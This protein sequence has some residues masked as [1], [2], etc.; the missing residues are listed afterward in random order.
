MDSE[1]IK[2]AIK[3]NKIK[4]RKYKGITEPYH[5]HDFKWYSCMSAAV[6]G[7][8]KF[9]RRLCYLGEYKMPHYDMIIKK[10][11]RTF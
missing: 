4:Y 2:Q 11:N 5:I 8:R 1:H 6:A 3:T 7:E 9:L 10:Y